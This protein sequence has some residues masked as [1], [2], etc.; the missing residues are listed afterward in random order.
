MSKGKGWDLT[1]QHSLEG[2]A[3]WIR[4]NSGALMVLVVR[5]EDVALA[6]DP[7]IAAKDI[8]TMVEVA[9]P[10]VQSRLAEKRRTEKD[11]ACVRKGFD[12]RE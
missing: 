6:V 9:M 7:W 11:L 12:G 10:E 3:E 5:P 1:S 8:S 2:A 4:K